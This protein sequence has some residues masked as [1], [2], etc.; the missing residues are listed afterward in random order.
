MALLLGVGAM[1]FRQVRYFLAVADHMNFTRAA[2]ACAVSQPSLTVAIQKL[3]NE[4]GGKLFVRDPGQLSLTPLGQ[5]MRTHL[6]RIDET[7]KAAQVAAAEVVQEEME[8]IDLGVMCT[9]GPRVIGPAL[10]EWNKQFPNAELI[11]HDVW[12]EKAADLLLSGALDCALI[13]RQNALPD[14][15]ET[16]TLMREEF[17]LAVATNHPLARLETITLKDLQ[18]APYLDRLRCEFRRTVFDLAAREKLNIDVIV[19]SE[20]EDWIQRLVAEG[21]G[22]T[23]L[24]RNSIVAEGIITRPVQDLPVHRSVEIVTVKGRPLRDV[25]ARFVSFTK[26]FE[27]PEDKPAHR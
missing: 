4:L 18:R 15:F 10:I 17:Q 1:E 9:I 12:G 20:R 14:R 5:V 3:E 24:P 11:I 21:A 19:R 2:E 26:A 27:W 25:V 8:R 13:A 22:V 16:S 23:L 7:R 6:A